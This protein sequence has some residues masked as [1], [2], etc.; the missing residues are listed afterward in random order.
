M[1][2][3]K[4]CADMDDDD[5]LQKM[6]YIVLFSGLGDYMESNLTLLF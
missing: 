1:R 6:Q 3:F 5:V 2:R 4:C